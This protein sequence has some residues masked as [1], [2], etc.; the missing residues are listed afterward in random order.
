M[1]SLIGIVVLIMLN[2]TDIARKV[3]MIGSFITGRGF[4]G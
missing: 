3:R 4:I 2:A 1:V